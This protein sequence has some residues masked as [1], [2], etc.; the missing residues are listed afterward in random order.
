MLLVFSQDVQCLIAS[1]LLD[2]GHEW[3][4]IAK[5][6]ASFGVSSGLLHPYYTGKWLLYVG[7]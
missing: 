6:V 4:S 3:Y 1:D 5:I 7:A 2:A